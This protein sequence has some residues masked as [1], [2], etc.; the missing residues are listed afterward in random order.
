MANFGVG[1]RTTAA[2][3]V[4]VASAAAILCI[5]ACAAADGVEGPPA[6]MER[7][8]A[9]PIQRAKLQTNYIEGLRL[10]ADL[11]QQPT[12]R[13][14][15][16]EEWRLIQRAGI[17]QI[18]EACNGYLYTLYRFH[19][20]QKA[21][22]QG[23]LAAT[24]TTGVILGLA[25][26]TTMAIGITAAALGLSASLFDAS[27]NSVLF[28]V[29]ASA[30]RNVVQESRSRYLVTVEKNPPTN[31]PDT[32]IS[33]RGYLSLCTPAVIEAN[34]NNAANGSRNSVVTPDEKAGIAAAAMAAPALAPPTVTLIPSPITPIVRPPPPPQA[35]NIAPEETGFRPADVE[36]IQ[37]ALCVAKDGDPGRRGSNSATRRAIREFLSGLG[38]GD[39]ATKSDSLTLDDLRDVV[40]RSRVNGV[41]QTCAERSMQTAFEVGMFGKNPDA[42]KG[43]IKALQERI[44]AKLPPDKQVPLDGEMANLR[45]AVGALR[46][47][48]KTSID[49]AFMVGLF[50]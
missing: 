21:A 33:L 30:V 24:A 3:A 38:G 45:K 14:V 44:N 17:D 19:A 10:S 2:A 37:V 1:L 27:T 46:N 8:S 9:D 6:N 26:A 31:R 18:D 13:P 50:K 40:R 48:G 29:E 49:H 35:Q 11:P 12:V 7:L 25:G 41:L 20:Q 23:L 43:D 22:R 16:A 4:R 39:P 34:I 28:S 32:M 42:L 47:D 15:P 5:G 36:N